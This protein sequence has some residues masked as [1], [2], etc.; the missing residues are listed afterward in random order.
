[1]HSI[2]RLFHL[3]SVGAQGNR[4]LSIAVKKPIVTRTGANEWSIRAEAQTNQGDFLGTRDQGP[5]D[6]EENRGDQAQDR[7]ATQDPAG[8]ADEWLP[9]PTKTHTRGHDPHGACGTWFGPGG[10]ISIDLELPTA[11]SVTTWSNQRGL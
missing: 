9:R 10:C 5:G 8:N 7:A 4:H 1:M 3:N 6:Q 2:S 11:R